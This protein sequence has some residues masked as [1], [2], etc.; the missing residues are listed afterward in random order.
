VSAGDPAAAADR[1]KLLDGVPLVPIAR[2][3]RDLADAILS[4]SLMASKAA[5]DAPHVAIPAV[6]G[7]KYLLT[8]NCRHIANAYMLP[9]IY[10][11]LHDEGFDQLFIC[12]PAE[13]LGGEH[14][15]ESDT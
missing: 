11:L 3:A 15:P 10:Q 8:L 13:F 2:D 1:L 12:T 4:A 6:A 7:V 5:A 14:G 9:R